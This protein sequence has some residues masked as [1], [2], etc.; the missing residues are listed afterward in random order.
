MFF[1]NDDLMSDQGRI[2]EWR[3]RH[4]QRRVDAAV[5]HLRPQR[6]NWTAVVTPLDRTISRQAGEGLTTERL[7]GLRFFW[8]D[9]LFAAISDNFYISFV[10]LFALAFGATNGQIGVIT[11]VGNMLG[12]LAFIPGA[13]LVEKV[14][15]RNPV[16]IWTGGTVMRL[17][18]LAFALFPFF[19]QQPQVAI[20]LIVILE[21][22]RSFAGNLGNPAWTALV[23]DLVPDNLRGRYFGGRNFAMGIA[24]LLVAPLAGRMISSGNEMTSSDVFGYQLVFFLAFVFG[25]VSTYLFYRIGEPPSL[26]PIS[27]PREPGGMWRVAKNSPGYLGLVISAFVWNMALQLAAPFFNVYLVSEL[28]ATA[29][30]IGVLA[31]IASFSALLGQRYFGHALDSKGSFWVMRLC[32]FSI[33]FAPIAW[34]FVTA[35]WHV[36]PINLMVGFLWAGYNLANFNL[37]LEMTPDTHRARAVAMYQ[38]AVFSSA[39]AGP[40]LG[41]YLADALSFQ[42]VFFFS[43]V[44]RMAGTLLFVWLAQRPYVAHKKALAGTISAG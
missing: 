13:R 31:A 20:V 28:D 43:G 36:V 35:P 27:P 8:L 29:A 41:G 34:G 3:K 1:K 19:V 24:A 32:G 39:V 12:A 7:R 25:M 2:P 18:L 6:W 15:K 9:G 26:V 10:P 33:P 37:L 11:A 5:D 14:G 42:F 23:A 30:M 21:G 22:I 40:L 16:V 4:V 38:T 17:T 44:G